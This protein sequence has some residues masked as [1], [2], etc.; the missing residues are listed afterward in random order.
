V[1][2]VQDGFEV[3]MDGSQSYW[4]TRSNL[5]ILIVSHPAQL[6]I[7]L[8]AYNAEIG[9]EAPRIYISSALLI[10]KIKP[11]SVDFKEKLGQWKEILNR[12]K[13]TVNIADLR[14]E[15]YNELMV[16]YIL[17]RL[18]MDGE[19]DATKELCISLLPITADDVGEDFRLDIICDMPAALDPVK[20]TFTKL[21]SATDILR[22][23]HLLNTEREKLVHALH[24]A[25][26]LST[27]A[28]N[29]TLI[30]NAKRR[31]EKAMLSKPRLRWI[32]AINQ[33]LVLKYVE[34]ARARVLSSNCAE[35][36]RARGT[37]GAIPLEP[38]EPLEPLVADRY[39]SPPRNTLPS[40]DQ[41]VSMDRRRQ[42]KAE[43]TSL[44]CAPKL[45]TTPKGSSFNGEGTKTIEGKTSM[46]K[47]LN[48]TSTPKLTAPK[49]PKSSSLRGD[50][51]ITPKLNT[52]PT[53]KSSGEKKKSK[54]ADKAPT[55]LESYSESVLVTAVVTATNSASYKWFL[56]QELKV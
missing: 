40:I 17:R 12:Q 45:G 33:V 11:D 31:L 55:L 44:E 37:A 15:V 38:L 2:T 48:Q 8:I 32:K 36:F 1:K 27:A 22:A 54:V 50:K 4:R 6:C 7:E 41:P 46:P 49:S 20:V 34:K 28:D 16:R 39:R 14:K 42:F 24:L 10:A 5:D 21:V 51:L 29:F 25:E 13:K 3:L 52:T 19:V 9:V 56:Q 47:L 43:R 30:V 53:P 26:L 23:Q 18:V 35:W